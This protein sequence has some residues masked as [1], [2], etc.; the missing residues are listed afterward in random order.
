MNNMIRQIILVSIILAIG[1]SIGWLGF[2]LGGDVAGNCKILYLSRSELLEY[3]KVRINKTQDQHL[4]LGRLDE[5]IKLTYQEA[6]RMGDKKHKVIIVDNNLLQGADASSISKQV[7]ESVI[8]KLKEQI[9][10]GK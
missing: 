2:M 9:G 10:A 5:A 3:E 6:M 8:E 7:H 1:I 4:F